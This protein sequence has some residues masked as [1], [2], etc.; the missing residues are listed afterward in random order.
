MKTNKFP[1]IL[2]ILLCLALLP[3]LHLAAADISVETVIE[4]QEAFV[5]EP[6]SMQIRV[7]GS[8]SAE[9]PDLSGLDAFHVQNRG[10]QSNSSTQVSNIN[11]SWQRVT[12]L[13]Y[14][15]TYTITAI[16]SGNLTIPALTIIVDGKPY[17]TDALSIMARKP[18]ETEDFK[19]RIFLS[20]KNCYAGEPVT[21]TTTW[22]VGKD[23][24]NF[25]FQL[26]I[27][28]DADFEIIPQK[29]NSGVAA[30][31]EIKIKAG[32]HTLTAY[33][34]Q[35]ELNGR[36]FLT[37]TLQHLLVV[38]KAGTFTLPQAT[39]A[40]QVVSG[41]RQSHRRD[42][43]GGFSNFD[44]FF[45]SGRQPRYRT[46]VTPSNEPV[47]KVLPLPKK[48]RPANFTGLV[49]N[50]S[51]NAKASPLEVHIG[52]PITLTVDINGPFAHKAELPHLATFL[53]ESS[54]KIPEVIA[55]AETEESRKTFSQT[56]RV[57]EETV[58]EIPSIELTYFDPEKKEYE[59]AGTD[60]IPLVVHE[61]RVITALDAVGAG[62][63]ATTTANKINEASRGLAANYEGL[64]VLI[65][66]ARNKHGM[67]WT[68]WLLFTLPPLLFLLMAIRTFYRKQHEKNPLG[69]LSKNAMA[70]LKRNL[71]EPS[72]SPHALSRALKEY[73][74]AK[75][76]KNPGSLLY[77]D[78][79]APL[80]EI[81]V[82]EAILQRLQKMFNLFESWQ[83]G[84]EI[85]NTAKMNEMTEKTLQLAEEVEI[86]FS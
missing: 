72:L 17:R 13:G 85:S 10:G 61:N 16:K 7:D 2:F 42:P 64:D 69:K 58:R 65:D 86:H 26:P 5:G 55:P 74:G 27:L 30:G 15:F 52:D 39:V 28:D 78:I 51:I 18:E 67:T 8:S 83:Y 76:Q 32:G 3:A 57:K 12:H 75:L 34:G 20:S 4:Q 1:I 36:E 43:S 82:D 60:P 14:I 41:F 37:V 29:P 63:S 38:K 71:A 50:Y 24:N 56:I 68:W 49:G 47:L 81:G 35:G 59:K 73:L 45:G 40:C 44:D 54:F 22:F 46:L 62:P 25:E 77:N 70:T 53:S 84:G 9:E 23:V 6:F 19:L 33:K 80:K 66:M 79:H 21:M 11:G 31:D 48:N